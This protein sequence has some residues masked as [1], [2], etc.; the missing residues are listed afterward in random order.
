LK[1][2]VSLLSLSQNQLIRSIVRF[3]EFLLR[4]RPS[5]ATVLLSIGGVTLPY[6]VLIGLLSIRSAE[7]NAIYQH[8]FRVVPNEDLKVPEKF[9][10]A[11]RQ[12]TAFQLGTPDDVQLHV[13]H[14]LPLGP[15]LQNE[16]A[17]LSQKAAVAAPGGCGLRAADVRETVNF[18][19]LRD[20]PDAR[21]VL[22]THGS[23]G[24]IATDWRI[25]TYRALAS[26]SANAG[27][28][29]KIHVLAFDY[30]GFGLS[31][32][33]PSEAGLIADATAVFDWAVHVARVPPERIVLY[34]QSMGAGVAAGLAYKLLTERGVRVAGLVNAAGF[35][36]VATIAKTYTLFGLPLFKPIQ[37]F[38]GLLDFL[39]SH[40]ESTWRNAD[41]IA[42]LVRRSDRFHVE[43][44][45]ARDDS[46]AT[47][48]NATEIYR[49][50]SLAVREK[51]GQGEKVQGTSV[52][53]G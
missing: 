12:V 19:M 1:V 44:V 34:G 49:R 47:W 6:A 8:A 29:E 4:N 46:I 32:G 16:Q 38:P 21:L 15:Y 52:D 24:C 27:G 22:H 51:E 23:C 50:A 28:P 25:N 41:R 39:C 37:A 31:G 9:G 7:R 42:D 48:K 18:Q 20:D 36:D 3:A 14:I 13:W 5:A 17:L 45:H 53:L 33:A 11:P 10:F 26:V 43:T 40:M 35:V 2:S 30:R